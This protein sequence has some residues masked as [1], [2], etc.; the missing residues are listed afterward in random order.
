MAEGREQSRESGEDAYEFEG[1]ER[2]TI[3]LEDLKRAL[4]QV[5]KALAAVG[6]G[7]YGKCERCG[8]KIEPG[9]LKALPEATLC[10]SCEREV[11]KRIVS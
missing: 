7:K 8:R 1:H 9:R 10:L 4:F 11:E 3:V 6:L 5:K 2:I